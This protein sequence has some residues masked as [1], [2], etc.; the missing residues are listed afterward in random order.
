MD[1]KCKFLSKTEQ[2]SIT[3]ASSF[4]NVEVPTINAENNS[5]LRSSDLDLNNLLTN[6]LMKNTAQTINAAWRFE[7]LYIS[8]AVLTEKSNIISLKY[9]F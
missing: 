5:T 9:I 2:Q 7:E 3:V 1:M 4:K 8:K 6:S